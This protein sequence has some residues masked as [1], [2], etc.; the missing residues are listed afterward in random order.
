EMIEALLTDAER[1]ASR[2]TFTK[3]SDADDG[4]LK[5]AAAPFDVAIVDVDL[6]G[7][8]DG[9][10]LARRLRARDAN[11]KICV[12]SNGSPFM[13]Q[14][15]ATEAGGD[16]FLPKPM[17]LDHLI[18]LLKTARESQSAAP[19]R[20]AVIDD[21][22][23]ILETWAGLSGAHVVTFASPAAFLAAV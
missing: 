4:L 14:R 5:F 8:V 3:A 20:V 1:R 12:H 13:L 21:D 6:G 9:L 19:R 22:A 2:I 23:L 15:Q 11:L 10:E 16:L 7:G 18:R 17:A